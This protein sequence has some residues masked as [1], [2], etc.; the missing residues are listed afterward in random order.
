M[1]SFVLPG[2]SRSVERD[3]GVDSLADIEAGHSRNHKQQTGFFSRFLC[4]SRNSGDNNGGS[5]NPSPS[6]PCIRFYEN[7]F[8]ERQPHFLD[9]CFL[10][11]KPL[12]NNQDIFMYRG[13]TPFCSEE[14]RYNQIVKDEVNAKRFQL[15]AT[16]KALRNK[17]Q[18]KTASAATTDGYHLH[19]GT[20]A[21]A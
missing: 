16:L 13:D 21:A 2:N 17:E 9:A 4:Y 7:R 8:E 20:V 11:R 6:R 18:T 5:M 3:T 19:T 12:G 15:S 1:E 14:C 10:C